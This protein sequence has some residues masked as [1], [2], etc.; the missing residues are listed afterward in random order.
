MRVIVWNMAVGTFVRMLSKHENAVNAVAWV[1]Q[2]T[3]FLSASLDQ[4]SRGIG[5]RGRKSERVRGCQ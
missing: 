2:G 5:R 1:P 3:H 4:V